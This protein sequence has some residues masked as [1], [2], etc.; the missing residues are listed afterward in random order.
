MLDKFVTFNLL[1]VGMYIFIEYMIRCI[2]INVIETQNDKELSTRDK[3]RSIIT[4]FPT[5]QS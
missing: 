1:N 4:N 5:Y 3:V 2:Y